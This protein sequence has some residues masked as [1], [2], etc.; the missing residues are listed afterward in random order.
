M[1]KGGGQAGGGGKAAYLG[2]GDC[3]WEQGRDSLTSTRVVESESDLIPCTMGIFAVLS[4]WFLRFF[5]TFVVW[6]MLVSTLLSPQMA[7]RN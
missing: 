5:Q 2:K 4:G 3:S 7:K 6:G 1:R